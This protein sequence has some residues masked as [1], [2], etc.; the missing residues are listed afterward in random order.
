MIMH[1]SECIQLEFIAEEVILRLQSENLLLYKYPASF[2][3]SILKNQQ[4][5][6]YEKPN[7]LVAS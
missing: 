5:F 6:S 2:V 4:I 7:K 1:C 3:R